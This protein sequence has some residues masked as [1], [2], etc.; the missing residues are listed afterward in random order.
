MN[1]E[2]LPDEEQQQDEQDHN[3]QRA[4][5]AGVFREREGALD[6]FTGAF[7]GVPPHARG[8]AQYV[9]PDDTLGAEDLCWCGQP[10]GHSWPGKA[11]KRPHPR[12]D[13]VSAMADEKPYLNPRDLKAFDRKVVRA[14]CDLVNKYGVEYKMTGG[15]GIVLIPPHGSHNDV[16][17]RLKV[18]SKRQ[19]EASLRYIEQWAIKHVRPAKM[20]EAL[21]KLAERFNDP[22]KKPHP[23]TQKAAE[24][25]PEK[26]VEK[27]ATVPSAPAPAVK[28]E[29]PQIETSQGSQAPPKGFEQAYAVSTGEAM[30]WW[31]SADQKTWICKE[32]GHTTS[33]AKTRGGHMRRHSEATDRSTKAQRVQTHIRGIIEEADVDLVVYTKA[34]HR[35]LIREQAPVVDDREVEALRTQ[36]AKVTREREDLQAR[37]DLFREALQA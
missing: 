15:T 19:A 23:K 4:F 13:Q 16:S 5:F 3:T 26:P 14:L 34:E 27:P 2:P 10:Q 7:R 35:R 25:A 21:P 17:E 8:G 18:S 22:E 9:Q 24:P 37:L 1:P 11:S 36:L 30:N 28:P 20:E 29:A 6:G 32:C 33:D 12:G 31:V